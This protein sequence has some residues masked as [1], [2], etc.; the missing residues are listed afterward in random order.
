MEGGSVCMMFSDI[1]S[2]VHYSGE[3]CPKGDMGAK[4]MVQKT[5]TLIQRRLEESAD[6]QAIEG[7]FN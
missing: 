6:S 7:C 3:A 1:T 4:C 5:E 2:L